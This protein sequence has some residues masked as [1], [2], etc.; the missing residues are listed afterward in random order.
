MFQHLR[1]KAQAAQ[2]AAEKEKEK[3]MTRGPDG[4]LL[5]WCEY[6]HQFDVV[7]TTYNVLRAEIYVALSW[8]R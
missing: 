4:K 7:I 5:H 8:T 3:E 2:E 6:V 1:R